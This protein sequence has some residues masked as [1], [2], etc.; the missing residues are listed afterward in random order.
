MTQTDKQAHTPGPWQARLNSLKTKVFVDT[1]YAEGKET[2]IGIVWF[3]PDA[4]LIAAAPDLLKACEKLLSAGGL[5]PTENAYLLSPQV[6]EQARV[7]IA[8]AK[9]EAQ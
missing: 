4:H 2:E 5:S 9:G 3:P 6:V 1:H 8:K 7:A